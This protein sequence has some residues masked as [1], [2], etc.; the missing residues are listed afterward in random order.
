MEIKRGRKGERKR[1]KKGI[2]KG[3]GVGP[4]QMLDI[5]LAV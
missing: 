3:E 1:E 2:R 4:L 5:D